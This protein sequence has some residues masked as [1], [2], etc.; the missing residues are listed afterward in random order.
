MKF[1]DYFPNVVLIN[2][3]RRTDRLEAFDKRVAEQG[4]FYQRFSAV[5]MKDPVAGCRE[6]HIAVL[7]NYPDDPLFIFEDDALFVDDFEN[8]FTAAMKALP[9]DW[10]MAYLGAHILEAEDFNEYWL[11]SGAASSTHA[12][13][14]K[15]KQ[16]RQKA[17]NTLK[18]H[19]GHS[20]RA[21]SDI[22]KE[23]KVYIVKSTLIWQ[24]PGYSDIQECEVNYDHLYK[25]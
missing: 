23:S 9:D 7:E 10:D 14:I 8:K 18:A 3:D 24:A 12:Y 25:F 2:L 4:I 15:G 22:H 1:N 19:N 21:L 17:I 6:S 11:K 5:D 16:F 13:A 20:D